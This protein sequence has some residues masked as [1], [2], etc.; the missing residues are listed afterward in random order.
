MLLWFEFDNTRMRSYCC[1]S[2]FPFAP[3]PDHPT[4]ILQDTLWRWCAAARSLSV[5]KKNKTKQSKKTKQNKKQK[6]SKTKQKN[7]QNKTKRKTTT[8]NNKNKTNKQKTYT[9]QK[10]LKSYGLSIFNPHACKCTDLVHCRSALGSCHGKCEIS[11]KVL[12]MCG[13]A[14]DVVH[15]ISRIFPCLCFATE[16]YEQEL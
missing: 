2:P 11:L 10:T 8:N 1:C 14:R 3:A 12:I 5:K 6:Q 9:A 4:N 16:K 15:Y 13:V 7:K